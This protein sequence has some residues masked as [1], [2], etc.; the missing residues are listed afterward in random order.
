MF[1][2]VWS[3][4]KNIAYKIGNFQ[5]RVIL[6]IF[7]FIIVSPFA[8]GVKLFSNP[9]RLKIKTNSYWISRVFK[10]HDLEGAR[11]QF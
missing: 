5:A 2:K 4:W 7:Y 8:V 9:L 6:S 3:G 10:K 1:K 11:R